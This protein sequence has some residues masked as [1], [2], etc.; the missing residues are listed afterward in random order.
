M[1]TKSQVPRGP[2]PINYYKSGWQIG[3]K[4]RV[5]QHQKEAISMIRIYNQRPG[6]L[7]MHVYGGPTKKDTKLATVETLPWSKQRWTKW[8]RFIPGVRTGV[9][10]DFDIIVSPDGARGKDKGRAERIE[11]RSRRFVFTLGGDRFEW[12]RSWGDYTKRIPDTNG[13]GWKLLRTR[14]G[15][16]DECVA[17][18]AQTGKFASK[19]HRYQLFNSG[20]DGRLGDRFELYAY[21]T[22]LSILDQESREAVKRD[23]ERNARMNRQMN[24]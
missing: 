17:A 1:S 4:A 11:I 21:L 5:G 24:H 12:H 22:F 23:Q 10:W 2:G 16:Q 13:V 15:G 7:R 3:Q 19:S 9:P 8:L 14:P 18:F 20:A 6:R